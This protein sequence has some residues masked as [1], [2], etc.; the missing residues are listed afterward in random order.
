M[1]GEF[2]SGNGAHGNRGGYGSGSGSG[3]N[4]MEG[5]YGSGNG[6]PMG[7]GFGA[8]SGTGGYGIGGGYSSEGLK[9]KLG[10]SL[11]KCD[12]NNPSCP[13]DEVCGLIAGLPFVDWLCCN[14]NNPACR[15]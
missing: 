12:P 7:G 10:D 3:A 5:G 14:P 9:S 1:G 8:E 13:S 15:H 2:E 11:R 4:G 6:G